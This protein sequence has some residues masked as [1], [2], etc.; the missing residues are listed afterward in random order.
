[1][2]VKIKKTDKFGTAC[3]YWDFFSEWSA[4]N[5]DTS[6]VFKIVSK[7]IFVVGS[8]TLTARCEMKLNNFTLVFI[9]E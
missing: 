9:T 4:E 7:D 5:Q 2:N 1:M 6:M 8:Y 3:K